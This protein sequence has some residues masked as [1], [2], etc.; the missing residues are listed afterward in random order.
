VTGVQTCALPILK[1]KDR[2]IKESDPRCQG[3]QCS[4]KSEVYKP[5]YDEGCPKPHVRVL[6]CREGECSTRDVGDF[7]KANLES[8]GKVDTSDE[9]AYCIEAA[10]VRSRDLKACHRIPPADRGPSQESCSR[11]IF[12]K[13]VKSRDLNLPF[14]RDLEEYLPS[15]EATY[16]EYRF[17]VQ[18]TPSTEASCGADEDLLRRSI[19]FQ[20]LARA[21]RKK[22]LCDRVEIT[23]ILPEEEGGQISRGECLRLTKE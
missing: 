8:C 14:C 22:A 15:D 3:V 16:C 10:A 11:V 4:V 5:C 13:H 19:C 2:W 17:S 23:R 12:L 9:K 20:E 6:E 21:L 7:S 1:F 18:K